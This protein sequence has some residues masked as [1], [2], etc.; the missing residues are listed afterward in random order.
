MAIPVD[1]VLIDTCVWASFFGK[2]GSPEKQFIEE[3]ID[4]DRA[5][6]IGPV[7]AEILRG[8]HQNAQADW[9]A[10]RLKFLHRPEI[11][12]DDWKNVGKL[13]ALLAKR[14]HRK[15]P[16]T[17]LVIATVALRHN[18]EVYSTDPHFSLV[19]ELRKFESK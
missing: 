3:L 2:P 11:E 15:I 16:L 1:A 9:V 19:P 4:S 17:D 12:W 7:G 5:A 14:G 8:I 13:G 10:S 6:I 18:W